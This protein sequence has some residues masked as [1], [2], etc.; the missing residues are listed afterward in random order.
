M[1]R[2]GLGNPI[3]WA[4]LNGGPG[5]SQNVVSRQFLIMDVR[6]KAQEG[7]SFYSSENMIDFVSAADMYKDTNKNEQAGGAPFVDVAETVATMA[8]RPAPAT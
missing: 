7:T 8:T 4:C 1:S 5:L 2:R 3:S 6:K